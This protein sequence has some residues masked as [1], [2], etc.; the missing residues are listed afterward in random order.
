[1]RALAH[2]SGKTAAWVYDHGNGRI[3]SFEEA[4]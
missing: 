3:I 2:E 4:K 1:M